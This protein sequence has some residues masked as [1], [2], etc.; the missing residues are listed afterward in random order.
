[1]WSWAPS[2]RWTSASCKC[3]LIRQTREG[4]GVLNL[5]TG[6]RSK[7]D[8]DTLVQTICQFENLV[9]VKCEK[10]EQ[11]KIQAEMIR[12]MTIIMLDMI[13]VIFQS[14]KTCILHFPT[15]TTSTG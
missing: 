9:N 2:A 1:M 3:R 4:F 7:S 15:T 13:T 5:K 11:V 8:L 10:G 14:I 12:P 6:Q